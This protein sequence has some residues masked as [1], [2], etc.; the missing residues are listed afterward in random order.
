[1]SLQR[2][3]LLA[4]MLIAVGMLIVTCRQDFRP[5]APQRIQ[6]VSADIGTAQAVLVG[7]GDIARC[8]KGTDE[9]TAGILDTIPGTVFTTGDNIYVD[10]SSADYTN[11]YTPSWGRHIARTAPSAGDKDYLTAGATGYFGYFGAAAGDPT[12]GYYS[13]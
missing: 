8:D 5:T 9:A 12:K 2:S 6:R 13:D 7:A 4:S 10:G 11:C 3:V 1:M